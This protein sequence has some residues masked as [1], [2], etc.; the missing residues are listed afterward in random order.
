[1]TIQTVLL[2]IFTPVFLGALF[3][4]WRGGAGWRLGL[5]IVL[6]LIGFWLGHIIA[7]QLGWNFLVVGGLQIGI[8][9]FGSLILLGVGY[10]LSNK[11]PEP[12]DKRKVAA[13]RSSRK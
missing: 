7:H 4:L 12:E 1:M 9:S 10:W 5:Y 2:G 11:E 3:H 6:A 13:T 8:G